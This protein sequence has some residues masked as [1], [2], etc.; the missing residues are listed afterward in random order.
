[1]K[2]AII[3]TASRGILMRISDFKASPKKHDVASEDYKE[4]SAE[5]Q[6]LL[7][8][9]GTVNLNLIWTRALR[10]IAGQQRQLEW[11]KL[12]VLLYCM[13]KSLWTLAYV[14][15]MFQQETVNFWIHI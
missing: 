8:L 6:P 13:G 10:D 12:L 14:N 7:Y 9:R 3:I 5:Q 4:M 2:S 1:M 11:G 15:C